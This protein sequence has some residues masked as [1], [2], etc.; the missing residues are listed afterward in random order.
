MKVKYVGGHDEV[1]IGDTGIVCARGKTVDVPDELAEG[2]LDQPTN[3]ESVKSGAKT[4][5][6]E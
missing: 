4:K 3:W 1:E 2:L 6:S 5:E